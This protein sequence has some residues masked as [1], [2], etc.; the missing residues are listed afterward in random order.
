LCWRNRAISDIGASRAAAAAPRRALGRFNTVLHVKQPSYA[1]AIACGR[2][3]ARTIECAPKMAEKV[4]VL[5]KKKCGF[6][7]PFFKRDNNKIFKRE[8]KIIIILFFIFYFFEWAL[9]F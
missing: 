4:R 9:L 2:V 7:L 1:A 5:R 8:E 6:T 3:H